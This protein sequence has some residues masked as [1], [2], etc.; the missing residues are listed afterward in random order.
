[1]RVA[2]ED[3]ADRPAGDHVEQ[4]LKMC[5]VIRPGIDHRQRV[6]PDDIAVGAMKA[7]GAG[8]SSS[9]AL[10]VRCHFYPVAIAGIETGIEF[11]GHVGTLFL[12][13]QNRLPHSTQANIGK[14]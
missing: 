8:I 5:L 13:W 7:E 9:D 1:M 3:M 6:A 2:D 12:E 11:E 4:G 10:H 14:R